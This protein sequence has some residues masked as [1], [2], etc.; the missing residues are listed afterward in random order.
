MCVFCRDAASAISH[1]QQQLDPQQ[2]ARAAQ[3]LRERDSNSAETGAASVEAVKCHNTGSVDSNLVKGIQIAYS[4][5]YPQ[6]HDVM[7][8]ALAD[9]IDKEVRTAIC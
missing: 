6:A 2:P 1:I 9:K 3:V 7:C 8:M 4:S 5:C